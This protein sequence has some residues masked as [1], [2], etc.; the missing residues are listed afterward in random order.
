MDDTNDLQSTRLAASA[1]LDHVAALMDNVT[2]M[3]DEDF[4]LAMELMRLDL[5]AILADGGISADVDVAACGYPIS[6]SRD[7]ATVH[8]AQSSGETWSLHDGVEDRPDGLDSRLR[9][10]CVSC[11]ES[12]DEALVLETPCEHHYCDE[13]IVGLF[14]AATTDESLFPPR[15]CHQPVPVEDALDFLPVDFLETFRAK[16]EEFSSDDR[17]YCS[18][19]ECSVFIPRTNITDGNLASCPKC[20]AATCAECKAAHH[21][22]DCQ[23][24]AGMELVRQMAREN[25]WQTCYSCQR[26][27]E[28]GTGC[29]HMSESGRSPSVFI[30]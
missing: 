10:I 9:I 6:E 4:E 7:M 19:A 23:G 3:G 30:S 29:N 11:S 22:G 18:V 16:E 26:I 27:I 28:L 8:C 14:H 25:G 13:C 1:Q 5:E 15:C 20:N 2:D 17:I 24:D 21:Q 12:K